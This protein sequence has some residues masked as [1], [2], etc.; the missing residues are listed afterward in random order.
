MTCPKR[1]LSRILVRE[2]DPVTSII[3]AIDRG[4]MGIALVVDDSG[5][6]IG[7]I[8]DGDVR[9]LILR[10]RGLDQPGASIMSRAF[11]AV[12]EGTPAEEMLK[13]LRLH[14]IRH[15]PVLDREGRPVGL[16]MVDD[17]VAEAVER[18]T[19]LIMAGG[20]GKRLLPITESIPKPMVEVGGRP[21]LEQQILALAEAGFSR[22]WLAVNYMAHVIEH[23]FGD[24]ARFGVEIGY[25]RETTRLGTAGALA[26]LP[27]VPEGPLLVMNGD[28]LTKADFGAMLSF[29]RERRCV[30]TVGATRYEVKVP[31]GVLRVEGGFLLGMEEKPTQTWL[32]NAGIYVLEPDVVELVPR[33]QH[34]DMTELLGKLVVR[35]LP[36]AVF[37]VRERWIDIGS[38]EEL[39]R[40]RAIMAEDGADE[41]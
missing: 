7:T 25:I 6:L 13:V 30:A 8:T 28:V 11:H 26:L 21:I 38:P 17:L 40:A 18:R 23:H 39:N 16:V 19:A 14:L 34:Y 9:R 12:P 10:G 36:V 2:H 37:P 20:E 15:L 33:G 5:R 22:V 41:V 3:E 31:L 24:G 29:H 35:G 27:E 1:D 4:K 32:C